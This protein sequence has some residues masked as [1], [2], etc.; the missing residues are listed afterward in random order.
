MWG[1]QRRRRPGRPPQA[2]GLPIFLPAGFVR[3]EGLESEP[4]EKNADRR[5]HLDQPA[6]NI[7][8]SAAQ[9]EPG[10]QSQYRIAAEREWQTFVHE[11]LL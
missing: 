5:A 11:S 1:R 8:T 7:K 9:R 10:Q 6:A 2:E 3:D 4:A